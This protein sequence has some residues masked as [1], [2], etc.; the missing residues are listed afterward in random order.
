[1]P[2][3]TPKSVVQIVIGTYSAVTIIYIVTC[4]ILAVMK[5]EPSDIV[6]AMLKDAALVA[7]GGLGA[8]LTSA[9]SQTAEGQNQTLQQTVKETTNVET[10][11]TPVTPK[12]P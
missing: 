6:A 8:F 2:P 5:I 3:T 4:A 10:S 9:K 1:M 12:I 7:L 11:T